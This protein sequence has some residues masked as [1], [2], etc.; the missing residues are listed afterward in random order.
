MKNKLKTF[1]AV[2]QCWLCYAA[3]TIKETRDPNRLHIYV[4]YST[5]NLNFEYNR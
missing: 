3:D 2:R 5:L 4:L 1:P